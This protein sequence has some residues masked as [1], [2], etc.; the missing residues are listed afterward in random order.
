MIL[1]VIMAGGAGTRLWPMSRDDRP[2][3]FLNLSGRGTL[4]EETI[5][6]L[7]ALKPQSLVIATAKKYEGLSREEIARS[8]IAGTVLSE[9]RPRNTAAA[10][11][12][13][14]LYLRGLHGDGVMIVLPADH[15]ITR[16]DVFIDVLRTAIDR[17]RD[18]SLVTIGIAPSY[19][20]TGYGYIKALETSGA[21]RK[22]E[23]FVEKPDLEKARNYV[24][25]GDY[26]W[27][28][29]IFIWKISSIVAAFEKHLPGFVSAFA[30]LAQLPPE[31]YSSDASKVWELKTRIFDEIES[32][33]ID[34]GI[35]EKADDVAVIPADFGWADLGSWKS[36][37]DIL[38]SDD[39]GNR[40]PLSDRSVFVDCRD[41]SV[42]SEDARI[43]VVGL[44]DV[45]VVQ[46]GNEILVMDKKAS[47][48]VRKVVDIV[49]KS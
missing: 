20:E 15:Y 31:Q 42:F 38:A 25:S 8:G 18:G 24:A 35:M 41:C 44:S 17:A 28:S 45:V 49:R 39:R 5:D 29:G 46:A 19:P 16:P 12:Y 34:T 33:S 4:L 3:Q 6:R 27:N 47:Q 48:D 36:I 14:A 37:D 30:P 13:A 23:R 7:A 2:K 32:V 40:A 1:P 21:V 9:P 10:V 43:S 26:Y 22:V 11:L